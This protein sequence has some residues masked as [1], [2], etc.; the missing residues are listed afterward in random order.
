MLVLGEFPKIVP[1]VR[2]LV[3]SISETPVG[4]VN[5]RD[6]AAAG[7]QGDTSFMGGG[8]VSRA[9]EIEVPGVPTPMAAIPSSVGESRVYVRSGGSGK[10]HG[11]R[12]RSVEE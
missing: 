10:C 4:R 5:V 2:A 8:T 1:S 7:F 9:M 3:S 6:Q 11:G 12:A